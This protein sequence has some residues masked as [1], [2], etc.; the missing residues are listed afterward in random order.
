MEA[1]NTRISTAHYEVFVLRLNI[2]QDSGN[3]AAPAAGGHT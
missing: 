2:P 3:G 1:A